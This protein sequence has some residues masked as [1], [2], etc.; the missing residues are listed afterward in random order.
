[1]F[2][3]LIFFLAFGV[4]ESLMAQNKSDEAV[5]VDIKFEYHYNQVFLTANEG[6]NWL[7]QQFNFFPHEDAKLIDNMGVSAYSDELAE[8]LKGERHF[9]FKLSRTSSGFK[10]EGLKGFDFESSEFDCDENYCKWR[11]TDQG[12]S[13]YKE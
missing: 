12:V 10:I 9:I 13:S 6:C 2:T 3:A 1:M 8:R 5:H 11:F 7:Q 4:S